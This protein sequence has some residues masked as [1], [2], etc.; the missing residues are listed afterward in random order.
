MARE[1]GVTVPFRWRAGGRTVPVDCRE[2]GV[3]LYSISG[4]KLDAPKGIGALYVR[5]ARAGAD[6]FMAAI[7]S[8]IAGPARRMFP[9]RSPSG[10]PPMDLANFED[11]IERVART[12]RPAGAG[13]SRSR[14]RGRASTAQ[15]H[16]RSPNTTNIC[17][18]GDRRRGH[19]DLARPEGI[20]GVERLGL[21]ERRGR[22]V[23]CAAGHGSLARARPSSVRFS[24]GRGNTVE[25]V[26]ALI[27]AV[28]ESRRAICAA[29]RQ[30]GK[31]TA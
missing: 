3:D 10:A 5:K 7:M 27:E 8:A 12:A 18:D 31:L 30:P 6:A 13:H 26:D 28:A 16:Q 17:F 22:A 15:R 24:L 2:L 4:H 11:E 23:A 29:Y 20:C 9:A 19:G 21:F 14:A 25:Q 1:P